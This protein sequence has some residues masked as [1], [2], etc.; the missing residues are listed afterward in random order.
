ILCGGCMRRLTRFDKNP[1]EFEAWKQDKRFYVDALQ[2][3]YDLVAT[4]SDRCSQEARCRVCDIVHNPKSNELQAKESN[5]PKKGRPLEQ[6]PPQPICNKCGEPW[7]F[8]HDLRHC[9]N[10]M[11]RPTRS[12]AA[13]RV[14][15]E[16]VKA[17]G[18]LDDLVKEHLRDTFES[19]G[20]SESSAT[21]LRTGVK[22]DGHTYLGITPYRYDGTTTTKSLSIESARDLLRLGHLGLGKDGARK[23][24][25]ILGREGICFPNGGLEECRNEKWTVFGP[26]FRSEVL[27]LEIERHQIPY[28]TPFGL[29]MDV[30]ALLNVVTDGDADCISRLKFQLDGGR[31]FLKLS[32]NVVSIESGCPYVPGP[33]SVMKNFV[34]GLGQALET[35]HNL[36]KLFE[37]PSI[38]VL[39]KSEM[40]KQI[41]CDLKV[42]A[43]VVGIQAA[44]CKYPCPFCLWVKG[45]A[46]VGERAAS[47]DW[48][49][50]DRD[51]KNGHHNVVCEPC[52]CWRDSPMEVIALAPLH[53]LLG[54]VNKVYK[55]ICQGFGDAFT[56]KQQDALA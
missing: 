46:C 53:L 9:A 24:C 32:V 1:G 7:T 52:V 50:H 22:L 25:A 11:K 16:R 13:G 27:D 12:A 31:Q 37:Y 4:R 42:A 35:P 2:L 10:V 47:R 15:A 40:P 28:S 21:P 44:S 33:N 36:R 54:V 26:L 8:E 3:D 17:R 14:F 5:F 49:S 20:G 23:L 18:F 38:S 29:C 6:S 34:I 45:C 43:M 39:F 30:R 51:F 55:E 48:Q 41:A 19:G 56:A